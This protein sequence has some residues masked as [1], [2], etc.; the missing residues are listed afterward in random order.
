MH[1]LR[2]LSPSL[3]LPP[4]VGSDIADVGGRIALAVMSSWRAPTSSSPTRE[5][6]QNDGAYG[7]PLVGNT[8]LPGGHRRARR[9]GLR[10][11]RVPRRLAPCSSRSSRSRSRRS[12]HA[13]WGVL[14]QALVQMLF[15]T[16]NLAVSAACCS[17][18][19]PAPGGSRCSAMTSKRTHEG[20]SP[21]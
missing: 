4:T 1:P 3:A 10:W 13:F 14:R 21:W 18:R 19:P 5:T 17:G 16:K 2:P 7:V 11:P 15:F 9:P 20:N 8:H 12:F 6:V